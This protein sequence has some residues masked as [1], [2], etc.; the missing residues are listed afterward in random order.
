MRDPPKW[1]DLFQHEWK[2]GLSKDFFFLCNELRELL[3]VLT[4]LP[5]REKKNLIFSLKSCMFSDNYYIY[6]DILC[7][8][9]ADHL[10]LRKRIK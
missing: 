2:H 1:I 6:E 7:C 10:E 8:L 4:R 9:G 3:C 5:I